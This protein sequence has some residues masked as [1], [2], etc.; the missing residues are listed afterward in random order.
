[1][2][3]QCMI[4]DEQLTLPEFLKT[5]NYNTAAFGKWHLGQSFFNTDGVQEAI[6]KNTDFSKATV[7]G[8][9]DHGFDYFYGMN[10]TIFE[11][12]SI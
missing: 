5:F 8:P 6:N 9:N 12:F 1:M 7:D 10:G 2:K 11:P 3:K 4:E